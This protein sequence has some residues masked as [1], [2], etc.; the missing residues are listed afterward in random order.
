MTGTYTEKLMY[1]YI[2]GKL[3]CFIGEEISVPLGQDMVASI[4]GEDWMQL[5]EKPVVSFPHN[6]QD[7]LNNGR[8]DVI[9]T[10]Y[11]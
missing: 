6:Q 10:H 11:R 3:E 2:L 4:L 7:N 5:G 9:V 1:E 8:L